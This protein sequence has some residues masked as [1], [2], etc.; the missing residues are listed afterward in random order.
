VIAAFG[1]ASVILALGIPQE[2]RRRNAAAFDADSIR[3]SRDLACLAFVPAIAFALLLSGTV[4]SGL[5]GRLKPLVFLC[6]TVVPLTVIWAN[7]AAVLLAQGRYRAWAVLRLA[8]PLLAVL[9]LALAWSA[10][11]M[12][13]ELVI[14]LSP[15]GTA[16]TVVLGLCFVR[17]PFSGGRA[18]RWAL[19]KKGLTFSGGAIA[20]AANNRLDQ[21]LLLPLIGASATGYY[22]V[23]A[24]VS[25]VPIAL[26]QAVGAQE[27]RNLARCSEPERSAVIGAAI[28]DGSS[29]SVAACFV[30]GVVGP[31]AVLL[32]FGS[33]FEGTIVPLLVMTFGAYAGSVAY[34]GSML[35]IGQG[36]GLAMTI[37]QVASAATGV[38]LLFVL[39]PALGA[40]GAAVAAS[41]GFVVQLAAVLVA[42]R[43]GPRHLLPTFTSLGRV[44]ATLTRRA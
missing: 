25:V 3:S 41:I 14:I 28:R 18:G 21:V 19:A 26:G 34:V 10:G 2:L 39:A 40:I 23:A 9:V 29:G 5:P 16:L 15:V 1:L 4:F 8:Q 44:V 43:V 17:V 38:A 20:D 12:S 42:L 33:T 31:P 30:L 37:G 7:D 13:V 22:S 6:V 32:L 35:L 11:I 27:L 24:A 36:K